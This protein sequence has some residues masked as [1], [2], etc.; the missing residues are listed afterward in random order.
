MEQEK[1]IIIIEVNGAKEVQTA[2]KFSNTELSQV[3]KESRLQYGLF[4]AMA[5]NIEASFGRSELKPFLDGY[6]KTYL[7]A[8]A[9]TITTKPK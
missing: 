5:S 9:P 3:Q 6:I 2:V 7:A 8:D 4:M 1:T